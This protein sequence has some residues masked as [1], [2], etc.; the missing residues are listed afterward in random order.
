MNI[1]VNGK[2]AQF[3]DP[4]K[5]GD[6]LDIDIQPAEGAK[7][8]VGPA[9]PLLKDSLLGDYRAKLLAKKDKKD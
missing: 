3:T 8:P 4:I 9:K 2:P 1:L 5:N 7:I 6:T